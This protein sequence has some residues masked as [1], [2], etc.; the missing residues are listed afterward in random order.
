VVVAIVVGALVL[1]GSLIPPHY[2]ILST[3]LT[4]LGVSMPIVN[5]GGALNQF[6]WAMLFALA[7]GM[8]LRSSVQKS[9]SVWHPMH[10]CVFGFVLY[11]VISSSYSANGLMTALKAGTFGCLAVA[12]MLYGRLESGGQSGGSCKLLDQVYGCAVV[13]ALAC[14]LT[15]VHVLPMRP[16]YFA[17][18]FGNPNSLGAFIPLVAPVLLLELLRS[19]DKSPQIRA[20]NVLLVIAYFVFLLMSR[21]RGGLAATFLACGWWLYFAH[22]RAFG[23]FLGGALLTAVI[24]GLYFPENVQNLNRVYVYKGESYVLRTRGPALSVT[25][26]AAME[27]PLTG[28]GFGVSKGY[29]EDWEFGF[30]SG[31]AGREK[32][33]SFLALVEEVG[34]IGAAF[35][36]FPLAWV[37]V[38]ATRRLMDFRRRHQMGEEFWVTLTLSACLV[39]G[40]A[41]AS[42]EAWLTSVGFFST[43]LFWLVF[44]ILA[45]RLT[46]PLRVSP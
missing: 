23:L 14:A 29:S 5:R 17:G 41:N 11:A 32:V 44:G 25:W 45:A 43:I 2:L 21:S 24:Y 13:V 37:I 31:A 15:V 34:L 7:L 26:E 38:A 28:V 33:N 36:L 35:L 30:E 16:G 4:F 22:R 8:I 6:R 12:A 42:V 3:L 1:F 27:S 39:G 19:F 40:L 10:L 20:A 9:R 18:P 46:T